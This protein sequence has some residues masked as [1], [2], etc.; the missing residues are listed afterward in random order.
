MLNKSFD[1]FSALAKQIL[2]WAAFIGSSF[3]YAES[4]SNIEKI[5]AS[6]E[7][8]IDL[9]FARLVIEKEVYPGI[10]IRESLQKID[11]IV[12]TIQNMPEYGTTSLERMGTVLRYIYTPGPWN[13][14][15]AYQYDLDDPF[16]KK[17]PEGKSI[18][19]YLSTKKGNCVSM[20]ILVTILGQRL[21]VN[22]N[23]SIAPHHAFA[24][25]TDDQNIVTNIETTSGTLLADQQY[26]EAFEIHPEAIKYGIYL[27]NL[28]KKEAVA[29]MLYEIGKMHL[30]NSHYDKAH[31]TADLMLK[32]HPKLVNAM[33]LKGN[34][35]SRQLSQELAYLKANNLPVTSAVRKRLDPIYEQNLAW[36]SKAESLG[37]RE[38][39]PDF[40]EK[41]ARNIEKFKARNQ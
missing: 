4:Y 21:G 9:A 24:R 6:P 25:Y 39:S 1:S 3:A 13:N 28:T 27:Q 30:Y 33:L 18:A 8:Q 15:Q 5:L 14:Y 26:I 12:A 36:F 10:N 11:Q 34:I 29:F 19:N 17:N 20:P 31:H 22:V 40:D 7:D 41:Y 38:P 2:F 23:L 35:Y 37:W 16:G 32:Y